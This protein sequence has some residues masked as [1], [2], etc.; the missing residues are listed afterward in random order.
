MEVVDKEIC[1]SWI[2]MQAVHVGICPTRKEK[3]SLRGKT[4]YQKDHITVMVEEPK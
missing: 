1:A 3:L 4:V 2:D